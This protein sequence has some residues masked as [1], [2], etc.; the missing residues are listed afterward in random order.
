ML[1]VALL[2]C[3]LL[4]GCGTVGEPLY[5]ALNIP[6]RIGDLTAV[7]R[8][9]KIDIVFTIPPLTTEGLVLK[10]IGSV[11]LRV[12][13]VGSGDFRAGAWAAAAKRVD[14]PVPTKAGYVRV[15]TPAQEFVGKEVVLAVRVGNAKGRV[16]EWSNL[17]ILNIEQPLAKPTGLDA[18]AVPE[19]VRLT[20]N[21][22][23]E[24]AF[25]IFRKA[26]EEKEPAVLAN[27]AKPEYVDTSTEYGKTYEYHVQGIHDKTESELAG[28][29]SITPKDIFP[30][31]VP[32]G[33]VASAGVGAIELTWE[34]NT[35]A[36]FK[37]YRLY[38][39]EENGPLIKI[40]ENLE[41]PSYSDRKIEPGKHYTYRV[42]AVDQVGN[43]SNQTEPAGA[44][45]P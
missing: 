31:H 35:E 3:V 11:E 10:E 26:G 22:P 24:S 20:W 15:A 1:Y 38:R 27:S 5:P 40:A 39:S 6:T 37:E 7:E 16:S 36:D 17:V 28:P 32:T 2:L 23:G 8:G 33:L 9:D 41:A 29:K 43:E 19:G 45:A 4:T 18:K 13:P 12:G 25:R 30:P 42:S 44:T 14:V 34:R 21:A